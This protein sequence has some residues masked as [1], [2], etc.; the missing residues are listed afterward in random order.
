MTTPKQ[1]ERAVP[2]MKEHPLQRPKTL[3]Q[4]L[5]LGI[6]HALPSLRS[7]S[8]KI[9]LIDRPAT[10]PNHFK[11]AQIRQLLLPAPSNYSISILQLWLPASQL[12]RARANQTLAIRSQALRNVVATSAAC[13]DQRL[14]NT[15][16]ATPAK[17]VVLDRTSTS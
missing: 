10:A 12:R 17:L 8:S 4:R 9:D 2:L 3:L 7:S 15:S 11:N 14:S 6:V 13:E 16:H 5:S 1:H